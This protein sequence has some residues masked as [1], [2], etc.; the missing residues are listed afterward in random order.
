MVGANEENCWYP[1]PVNNAQDYYYEQLEQILPTQ[2]ETLLKQIM[3]KYKLNENVA[4]LVSP[5]TAGPT[6]PHSPISP[7]GACLNQAW[8]ISFSYLFQGCCWIILC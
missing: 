7:T 4:T 8:V 3:T 2:Y 5:T 1:V 6:S